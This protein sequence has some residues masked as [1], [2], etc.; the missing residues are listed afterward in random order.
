MN[1]IKKRILIIEDI[2]V[3]LKVAKFFLERAGCKTFQIEG[4]KAIDE[5]T[6]NH[7]SYDGVYINTWMSGINGI[8]ICKGIG[9]YEATH[10]DLNPI[11]II[12]VTVHF[13]MTKQFIAAGM[14]GV[15]V[16]PFVSEKIQLFLEKC[17]S[18]S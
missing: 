14:Q 8:E 12:A 2:P 5:L 15:I 6:N 13:S 10:L 16:K 11:P 3:D 18:L 7:E 1:T 17:Q 4:R 9:Q